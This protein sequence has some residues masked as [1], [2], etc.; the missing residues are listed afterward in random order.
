MT[1]IF[2]T[3]AV[4]TFA[5]GTAS[6]QV[7]DPAKKTELGSLFF[8][9]CIEN[10]EKKPGDDTYPIMKK[11]CECSADR[12]MNAF[13]ETQFAEMNSWDD[14]KMTDVLLPVI[15]ECMTTLENDLEKFYKSQEE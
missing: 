7:T 5:S 13:T 15:K 11:Y 8:Q 9:S 6:A 12:V 2:I 3:L 14:E 10:T 1:K 4:L